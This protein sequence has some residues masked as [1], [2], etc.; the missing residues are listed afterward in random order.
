MAAGVTIKHKR[1]A[2][3]FSNGELA[4][5]EWGLDTT[6]NVWYYSTNGT[7]VASI[8]TTPGVS[9]ADAIAYAVALG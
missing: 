6:N 4:A 3:A 8:S 1:K 9:Q 7:T 5:G 2:G